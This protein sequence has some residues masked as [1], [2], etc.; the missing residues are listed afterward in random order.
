MISATGIIRLF[1]RDA[2][3]GTMLVNTEVDFWESLEGLAAR[4]GGT[5][6]T[7]LRDYRTYR[8]MTCYPRRELPPF[9]SF[10]IYQPTD[11]PRIAVAS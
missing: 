6:V 8:Q 2:Y 5:C 1:G 11:R 4:V 3:V 9:L 7:V 10:E